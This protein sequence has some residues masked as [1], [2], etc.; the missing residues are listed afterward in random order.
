MKRAAKVLLSI[1]GLLLALIVAMYLGLGRIVWWSMKPSAPFDP[2]AA[3]PAPDYNN[4]AHWSALPSRRDAADDAPTGMVRVS[5]MG[6][7]LFS[8]HCK[9]NL[10]VRIGR[11]CPHCRLRG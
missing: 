7:N 10:G 1:V 2:R 9:W 11:T 6:F 8:R 3:P 4:P 5:V